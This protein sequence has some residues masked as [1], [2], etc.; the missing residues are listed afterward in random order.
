M[1][2]CNTCV[3]KG[4]KIGEE[5]TV[6][7]NTSLQNC[8]IGKGCVI[9]N[10]VCIGQDGFGFYIDEQSGEMIK[11]PQNLGVVIG[12]YVEIGANTCVDR[13]SWR[14]TQVGS[15]TK[16]DNLCQIGHNVIVG[17]KCMLC[18][19]VALG[20]SCTLGDCVVLGGKAAVR[21]HVEVCD[22]VRIAAKSGVTK[23]IKRKGDY[24]GFPAQSSKDWKEEKVIT[25]MICKQM[26]LAKFRETTT[27]ED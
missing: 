25:R 8:V 12:D 23:D 5:T 11:K 27:L 15:Y 18:G 10:G 4:V 24:A 1:L 22:Y 16:M 6:H 13:G 26:K 14:D 2:D 7:F 3:G 17:D 21:D 9:H 19:H 20:G